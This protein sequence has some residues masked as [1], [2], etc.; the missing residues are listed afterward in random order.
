MTL[1]KETTSSQRRVLVP[2]AIEAEAEDSV[3][4]DRVEPR[5]GQMDLGILDSA[6]NVPSRSAP[7]WSGRIDING[8]AFRTMHSEQSWVV[9]GVWPTTDQ[10]HFIGATSDS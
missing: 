9:L 7:A 3:Q 2:N 4:H 10:Q 8:S 6:S 5:G 1:Q